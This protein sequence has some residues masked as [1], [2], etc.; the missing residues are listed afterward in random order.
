MS[1]AGAAKPPSSCWGTTTRIARELRGIQLDRKPLLCQ[2][3]PRNE[4]IL[5][6]PR[7][8]VGR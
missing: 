1:R 8:L 7:N 2:M 3:S 4:L 6:A 5:F